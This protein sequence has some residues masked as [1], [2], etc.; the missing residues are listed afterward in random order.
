MRNEILDSIAE[1]M[2]TIPPLI[3]RS[4]RRKLLRMAMA[5][6]RE[7]I[8]PPHFEIMRTLQEA[9]TL[10]VTEIGE[11]L[12]IPRPQMTH[13]IDKLVAL[14]MVERQPDARDRRIINIALTG[15]GR[16]LLKKH[17]RMIESAIKTSLT[18]LTDDELEEAS[19]SLRTLR[20][21]LSKL[22]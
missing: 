2:F 15:S 17:R 22:E 11:R 9:G 4:I 5:H 7:D 19:T 6:V 3:G 10:H 12:Q 8:S 18:P 21:I 16:A 20:R 13:L 14:E 1:D